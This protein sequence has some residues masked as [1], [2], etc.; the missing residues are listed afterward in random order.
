MSDLRLARLWFGVLGGLAAW[1]AHLMFG[2]LLISF[3]CD[4][5]RSRLGGDT[6]L[7]LGYVALTLV[8]AVVAAAATVAA[9][10]AWRTDRGWRRFFGLCGALL[11]AL[12]LGTILL[13]GVQPFF[14]RPCL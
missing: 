8:L 3:G 2:Y 7:T 1:S 9:I 13:G 4:D 6:G 12:G 14:L 5:G 11:S 10:Q